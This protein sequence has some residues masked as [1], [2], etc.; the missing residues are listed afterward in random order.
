MCAEGSWGGD[1]YA[2]VRPA[3]GD[4]LVTKHRFNAFHNTDLDVILRAHGIR[5]IILTGVATNVC[6][7]STARDG[8]MRDYYVVFT[9][10]G[11]ATYAEDDHRATLRNIDR[12]FGQVADLAE[13]RAIWMANEGRGGH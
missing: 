2:G 4:P 5:T 8:F 6:V 7:E 3:P 10:D 12:F 11:T 1:F 13:L 9:A